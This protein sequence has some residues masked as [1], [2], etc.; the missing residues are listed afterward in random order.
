MVEKTLKINCD[1]GL[2]A[3]ICSAIIGIANDFQCKI[4]LEK[5]GIRVDAKSILGVMTLA[6]KSGDTVKII[7]NG[8]D[9]SKVLE[10]FHTELRNISICN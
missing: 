2:H 4:Y 10:S 1:I 3:E 9:E 5:N 8:Q 7:C 6:V